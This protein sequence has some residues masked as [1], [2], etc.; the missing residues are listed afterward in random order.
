MIYP[1][2]NIKYCENIDFLFIE[3]K[4]KINDVKCNGRRNMEENYKKKIIE[5]VEKI[6]NVEILEYLHTF[7]KLFLKKWG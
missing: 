5:L 4:C 3:N 1:H 6:E 7:I 2:D